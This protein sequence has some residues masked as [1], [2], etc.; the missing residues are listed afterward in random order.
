MSAFTRL[1][2]TGWFCHSVFCYSPSKVHVPPS[3][4]I[5]LYVFALERQ[6]TVF[7][8]CTAAVAFSFLSRSCWHVARVP[9]SK[10]PR[11]QLSGVV[12][13]SGLSEINLD[14]SPLCGNLMADNRA[15]VGCFTNAV[16][17][18]FCYS[19]KYNMN[20]SVFLFDDWN[21][22]FL[23]L[24][25]WSSVSVICRVCCIAYHDLFALCTVN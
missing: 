5:S 4:Y 1:V 12:I 25:K 20:V 6:I 17:A 11:S 13:H 2:T 14:F 18:S 21:V 8:S 19:I 9:G 10:D 15:V 7:H 3:S 24:S 22:T 16:T 23:R